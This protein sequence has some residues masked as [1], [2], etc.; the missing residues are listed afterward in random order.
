MDETQPP[1]RELAQDSDLLR[2]EASRPSLLRFGGER[3]AAGG[4]D[5]SLGRP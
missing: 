4:R 5:A 3:S 2:R 1:D